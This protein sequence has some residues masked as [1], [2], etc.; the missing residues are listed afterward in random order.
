METMYK[1]SLSCC[2]AVRR[3]DIRNH[4]RV[5]SWERIYLEEAQMVFVSNVGDANSQNGRRR[6]SRKI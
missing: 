6:K 2:E 3:F 1:E 4:S 5:E